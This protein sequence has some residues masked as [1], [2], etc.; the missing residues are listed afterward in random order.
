MKNPFESL[1]S[2]LKSVRTMDNRRLRHPKETEIIQ[3]AL[4]NLSQ[5]EMG[6]K[7]IKIY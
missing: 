3:I 7:I 2:A 5:S 4:N 6:S 1:N